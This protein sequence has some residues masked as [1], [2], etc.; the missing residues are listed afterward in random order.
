LN[1]QVV[2]RNISETSDSPNTLE[3]PKISPAPNWT[4]IFTRRPE[5]EPPGYAEVF[6]DMIENPRI[7]PSEIKQE[8]VKE[9]KRKR[10]LGREDKS[11]NQ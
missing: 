11:R 5:L 4:S 9:K 1:W 8:K 3:Y 2:S 6:I 10:S 7:K